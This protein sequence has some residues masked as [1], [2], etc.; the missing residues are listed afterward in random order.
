MS[1]DTI[2]QRIRQRRWKPFR[3]KT[4]DGDRY[5]VLHP[6]MIF[7]SK[8]SLTIAL[9]DRGEK[10]GVEPPQRQ[11]FVSPLHVTAVEDLPARRGGNGSRPSKRS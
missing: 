1:T 5:D 9:Y 6:E 3:L 11:V 8:T 4:S 7:V 10:P 2:W